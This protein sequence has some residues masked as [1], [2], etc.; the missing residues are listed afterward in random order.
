MS[1]ATKLNLPIFLLIYLPLAPIFNEFFSQSNTGYSFW[2]TLLPFFLVSWWV[3]IKN[4]TKNKKELVLFFLF[5][6]IIF[7]ICF[8]RYIYYY[9]NV[10]NNLAKAWYLFFSIFVIHAL[11]DFNFQKNIKS[12]NNILLL[13]ILF[14]GITGWLYLMGLPTIQFTGAVFENNQRFEGIYRS[15]NGYSS[16]LFSFF[17]IFVLINPNKI[18][19]IAICSILVLG[20]IL[21]SGSRGPLLLF[22]L[23]IGNI[24]ISSLLKNKIKAIV[25]L[26]IVGISGI[27]IVDKLPLNLN[28]TRLNQNGIYDENRLNKNSVAIIGMTSSAQP[29]IIGLKESQ[30]SLNGIE[31]SDN[32]LTL[33]PTSYGIIVLCFWGFIVLSF[34][35][36]KLRYLRYKN[37]FMYLLF[38][39]F[40]FFINNSIL[41]L[42]WVYVSIFG[43]FTI[44]MKSV[45]EASPSYSKLT[46]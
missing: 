31:I 21:A 37:I 10:L 12:I 40:I 6:L 18:T 7:L 1:P 36:F 19:L 3:I 20:G 26:I 22:I 41:W 38:M 30:L 2:I 46:K 43:Y 42:P 39:G 25:L 44:K 11:R 34:T 35:R 14:H 13:L 45:P 5:F 4:I 29:M 9:E 15:T 16:Y 23:T 17:L 28:D 24:T 32:S 33:I 27:Y 8:F